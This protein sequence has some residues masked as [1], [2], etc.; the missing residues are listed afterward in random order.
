M[1]GH[2]WQRSLF[3]RLPVSLRRALRL[4]AGTPAYRLAFAVYQQLWRWPRLLMFVLRVAQRLPIAM[5][6]GLDAV[7]ASVLAS[8]DAP[9][10]GSIGL[11]PCARRVHC[12][13]QAAIVA[14][15]T[16]AGRALPGAS[17]TG[18]GRP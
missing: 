10:A 13:L 11:G 12:R 7:I 8:R 6:Q 17:E 14:E 15:Q 9:A 2:S 18:A 3:A 1:T 16:A 5:P 4:E